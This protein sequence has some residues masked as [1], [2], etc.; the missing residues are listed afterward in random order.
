IV[1]RV[2]QSTRE[3]V[4][5]I[6]R[7]IA[8][9]NPQLPIAEAAFP[10]TRLVGQGGRSL[11]LASLAGARIAAVCGIGNPG[12]FRAT[13]HSL[14][15]LVRDFHT[16]PDHHVYSTDDIADLEQWSRALAI[17]AV[18][19]TQKDLVKFD[20]AALGDCPLWALEIGTRLVA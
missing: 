7:E 6:R 17:D 18:V 19:C 14:G 1:T 3:D 9:I 4:E 16:F 12:A 20:R 11:E 2:D 10:A 15:W 8:R 13:L 5:A